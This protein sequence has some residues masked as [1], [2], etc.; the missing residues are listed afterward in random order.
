MKLDVP[1]C[2]VRLRLICLALIPY[3][4][5]LEVLYEL[6]IYVLKCKEKRRNG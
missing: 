5:F 2:N 3:L 4:E 1:L 6:E